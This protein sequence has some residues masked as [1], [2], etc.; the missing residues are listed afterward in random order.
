MKKNTVLTNEI[1]TADSAVADASLPE[2]IRM[3]LASRG[4]STPDAIAKFLFPQYERDMQD[5]SKLLHIQKAAKRIVDGMGRGEKILLYADYDVDGLCAALI[6]SE[7]FE[8]CNHSLELYIPD[9]YRDG[10][11]VS[12]EAVKGFIDDGVTLIITVDCGI[13]SLHAIGESRA[14]GVDVVVIDHHEA[15]ADLPPAYAI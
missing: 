7:F 3:I 13:S 9:R 12:Y 15:S 4:I 14:R 2:L 6:L 11:G 8:M 5:P 1:E 10:H